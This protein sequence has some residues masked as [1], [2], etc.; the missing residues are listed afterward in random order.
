MECHNHKPQ[1][2]SDTKRKRQ[3]TKTNT[4]NTY[5]TNKC[6]RRNELVKCLFSAKLCVFERIT[7]KAEKSLM[8]SVCLRTK[9]L[10]GKLQW[11]SNE[12]YRGVQMKILRKPFLSLPVKLRSHCHDFDHDGPRLTADVFIVVSRDYLAPIKSSYEYLR[13]FYGEAS[14]INEICTILKQT[15]R[16]RRF[17]TIWYGLSKT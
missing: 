6:T 15:S 3:M 11:R 12:C 4:Y 1:P 7:F 8:A 17:L 5:K 16:L 10:Y 14:N 9:K 2:T 13:S